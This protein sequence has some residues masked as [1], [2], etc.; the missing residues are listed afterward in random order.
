MTY[1]PPKKI[2]VILSFLILLFGLYL[3]YI[4]G[5]SDTEIWE[6]IGMVCVFIS[7]FLLFILVE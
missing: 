7:W 2:T 6:I 3:L 4:E 5:F 1:S